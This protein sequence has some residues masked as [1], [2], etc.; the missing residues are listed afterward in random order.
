MMTRYALAV[1]VAAVVALAGALYWQTG[2]VSDLRADNARMRAAVVV[3][4][5]AREQ[6]Q[7]AA[8]VA[9][10]EALRQKAKADEYEQVKEA[11]RKGDFNAPLPDD[12]RVLLERVLRGAKNR[13]P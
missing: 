3:L 1:A 7:A 13:V 2:R 11:F 12:F 4:E 8:A 5:R 6:S 9:Q 10:Q